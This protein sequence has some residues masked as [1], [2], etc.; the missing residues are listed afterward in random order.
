M[1][2]VSAISG[3]TSLI[4]SRLATP[5]LFRLRFISGKKSHIGTWARN[6]GS[7]GAFMN[8]HLS[9]INKPVKHM[10]SPLVHSGTVSTVVITCHSSSGSC[11]STLPQRSSSSHNKMPL[12]LSLLFTNRWEK[13]GQFSCGLLSISFSLIMDCTSKFLI[14]LLDTKCSNNC[15]SYH[16]C[17]SLPLFSISERSPKRIENQ[18]LK[19]RIHSQQH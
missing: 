14:V 15:C 11:R 6:Y 16:H 19:P 4:E 13:L 2:Q 5:G 3:L 9:R 12:I 10:S 8:E 1:P 7:E 18:R 17:S